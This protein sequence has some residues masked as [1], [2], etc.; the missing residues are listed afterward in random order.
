MCDCD[1]INHPQHYA[2]GK[3]ECIDVMLEEFG[4][5]AV[6]AFCKLN[7]FK[8]LWRSDK[9]NGVEDIRKADRYLRKYIELSES[10]AIAQGELRDSVLR[11]REELL[12]DKTLYSAFASSVKSALDECDFDVI[13]QSRE[14]MARFIADRVIGK[15]EA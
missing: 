10:E 9:K 11:F 15:E 3:Y 8:Y 4:T 12:A 1:N 6:K 2:D 5:E 13:Y 7:A 14:E